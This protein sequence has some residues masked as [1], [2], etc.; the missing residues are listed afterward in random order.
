MVGKV[1]WVIK[2]SPRAFSCILKC[3]TWLPTLTVVVVVVLLLWWLW[4]CYCGGGGG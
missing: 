2:N 3:F 1:V 4:C